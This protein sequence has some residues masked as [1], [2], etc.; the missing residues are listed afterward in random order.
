MPPLSIRLLLS[1]FL[2]ISCFI[3]AR[4][5]TFQ[6]SY[7]AAGTYLV[8]GL[9]ETANDYTVPTKNGLQNATLKVAKTDGA[10]ISFTTGVADCDITAQNGDVRIG[11]T[12]FLDAYTTATD[13][14]MRRYS[15]GANCAATQVYNQTYTLPTANSFGISNVLYSA[16]DQ[17]AFVGGTLQLTPV[18]NN[19][20]YR[21]FVKKINTVTGAQVWEYTTN[22]LTS[23]GPPPGFSIKLATQA[24]GV[25]LAYG[26]SNNSNGTSLSLRKLNGTG[27]VVFDNAVGGVLSFITNISENGDGSLLI[28]MYSASFSGPGDNYRAIL[29]DANGNTLF[30]LHAGLTLNAYFGG[31]AFAFL[32]SFDA[33]ARLSNG[34]FLLAGKNTGGSG[35]AIP[36][37]HISRVSPNGTVLWT[38]FYPGLLV[39]FTHAIE[40]FPDN[41][42]LLGGRSS[43]VELYLMKT[44]ADGNLAAPP[45]TCTNNLLTNPGFESGLTGWNT[46]GDV[47]ISTN[48]NSGTKSAKVGGTGYGSVGFILPATPGTAYTAKVWAKYTGSSFRVVELRFLN[49]SYTTLPGAAQ[50]EPSATT[51]T[52]YTL[53]GTAPAGTAYVYAIASKD[54]SGSIEVDD[55]CLTAGGGGCTMTA[56]V[57]STQCLD[58]GTPSNPADDRFKVFLNVSGTNTG[59]GWNASTNGTSNN[60]SYGNNIPLFGEFPI[61]NGPFTLTLFDANSPTAPCFTTVNII[62]PTP[63]SNGGGAGQID[64]SL[65]LQQ[66]TA[67]PAQ[68]SNYS[69]KA[70]INNAGPQTATGVKVKFAK[71]TGVVYVGGNQFTASQGSFNPNGDEVWTVG[72][73]PANGSATL[74]VNYFLLNATAPVAYAQVTAANETDSDSQPNN[75]T[76][77]TPVQ[78]DE[79]STAGG[80]GPTPQADLTIADLQIPTASVAAGA[81][82]S[83]NFDTGNAGTAAVPGNFT[84]KSYIST[85]NTLSAN[86]VQDG[87]IN[88]GSYGVGFSVQ[89]VAGASTIPASLAAG[90][91]FLIVKIDG[92][93]IVAEGNENNNTVVKA[94]TVT[95]GGSLPD[96]TISDLQIQNA[97]IAA[98]STLSFSFDYS[99]IGSGGSSSVF[100]IKSY[101]STDNVLSP[102]DIEEAVWADANSSPGFVQNDIPTNSMVP[103]GFAAGNY[104][105]IL[106][107][108]GDNVIT[109]SNEGNNTVSKPFTL[110]TVGGGDACEKSLVPGGLV[111]T[112]KTAAGNYRL[113]VNPQGGTAYKRYEFT[114]GGTLVSNLSDVAIPST[115]KIENG[116]V[117]ERAG[118]TGLVLQEIIIPSSLMTQYNPK[119]VCRQTGTGNFFMGGS[120]FGPESVFLKLDANFNVLASLPVP[121]TIAQAIVPTSWG[122]AVFAAGYQASLPSAGANGFLYVMSSNA[123]LLY[124]QQVAYFVT[125]ALPLPCGTDAFRFIGIF[126]GGGGGSGIDLDFETDFSFTQQAAQTL[127]VRNTGYYNTSPLPPVFETNHYFYNSDGTRWQ[128]IRRKQAADAQYNI[129]ATDSAWYEKRSATDQLLLHQPL[130]KTVMSLYINAIAEIETGKL[131]FFGTKNGQAWHYY[132]FCGGTTPP[133]GCTAITITPGPSKITI[134]GFSAP[135]VLIKV[136]KPNWTLAFECL[137]GTCSNPQVV[138]GLSIGIH[139]VQVKLMNASWGEICFLQQDVNVSSLGSGNG[140][141]NLL[142][143]DDRFRIAFDKFYPN[144]AAHWLNIVLFSP[145]EQ[146]ITL[147]FYDQQGRRSHTLEM[148]AEEGRNTLELPVSDWKSGTYNVIARGEGL[149]AYGRFMK[150]W[151]E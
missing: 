51:Y 117:V 41:G 135:H 24:G 92:D 151:E 60:Y 80:G 36:G 39:D 46:T 68:W 8:S 62:P 44:D 42:F 56:T 82:L 63:C 11:S 66:L 72:S 18:G 97:S 67:T 19:T 113:A 53:N 130:N 123:G 79:A 124:S 9:S 27:Q 99:N 129:V 122:G 2:M 52:E 78:D 110:I 139:H 64:L 102:N 14:G 38:R 137:D 145:L 112:E 118:G 133:T 100:L 128:I 86:D 109:E 73:I 71:P 140:G 87:I 29:W 136:F 150:V 77:P 47:T 30:S 121:G 85:D 149:P 7:P 16:A 147:D 119:V 26:G 101:L 81:I 50:A 115:L 76:P 125:S 116:K 61:V 144:P 88:T 40:T 69:V 127:R 106:K 132:P 10:Q 59:I 93:G 131:A 105:I 23:A 108:D 103:P 96:L 89:N 114:P 1:G 45:V 28:R 120:D 65:A 22:T 111:C 107:V 104:F 98:G 58:N 20:Q 75:G 37:A 126:A 138:S 141:S 143:P 3:G 6:K 54:G 49:A 83:Y 33:H 84:I 17:T 43:A 12:A 146:S 148:Q 35:G 94:F 5:Q 70:T 13:M 32:A 21:W 90:S 55:W 34:D 134:T 74:T 25:I 31:P 91:Y 4:S 15:L 142:I 48:A 57:A 95:S